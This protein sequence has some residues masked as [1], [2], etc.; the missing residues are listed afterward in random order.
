MTDEDLFAFPF[1]SQEFL[2]NPHPVWQ[3][4]IERGA[5]LTGLPGVV[6]T[7]TRAAIQ[8][9][10]RDP[11][12]FSSAMLALSLGNVRPMIP[13]QV[14][15]PGHVHYR[16]LLDPLFAPKQ[17]EKLVPAI[18]ERTNTLI[19]G[20]I[21]AG[22]CNFTDQFAVPLPAW[23]FLRLLGCPYDDLA[24]LLGFVDALNR[25]EGAT[26]EEQTEHR[27]AT[28]QAVYAYFEGAIADRRRSPRD[29][30][31]SGFLTAEVDGQRLTQEDILD[32]CYLLLNAGL[33]T[34][35]DTLT[36]SF[37]Y[38]AQHPDHRQLIIDD[39][40]VIPSAVE[41]LLRWETPVICI[42]RMAEVDTEIQGCPVAKGAVVVMQ[43]GPANLDPN[44]FEDP[45]EVDFRRSR[46]AHLAFGGGIH[47]CLGSHVARHELRVGLAEWH[48]R[49]PHYAV[50]PGVELI[51]KTGLRSVE[52]LE[53]VF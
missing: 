43:S 37:A 4:M 15:P 53:L 41:E 33:D 12:R 17:M 44:E 51:Y 18:T 2:R 13:L 52:N 42:P 11:A 30:L 46:N 1:W 8:E 21:D 3:E 34:V 39:P 23:I 16:R 40:G 35:T 9:V 28:G 47:R 32:I 6:G 10:E 29:D 19:D 25:P 22:G 36:C 31:L 5:V 26:I 20:F 38:L 7:T 45:M 48:R 49:I 24:T 50:R 27:N 14:N